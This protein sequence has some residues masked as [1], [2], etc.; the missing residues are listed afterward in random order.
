MREEKMCQHLRISPLTGKKRSYTSLS[1]ILSYMISADD[2]S[3][4]L[5]YNLPFE[6]LIRES[7]LIDKFRSVPLALF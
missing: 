5:S 6:L 1:S 3:I 7:L 4:I 2:F